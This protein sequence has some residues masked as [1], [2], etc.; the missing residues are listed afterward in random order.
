MQA[1]SVLRG[2]QIQRL[3]YGLSIIQSIVETTSPDDAHKFRDGGKGWTVVE[4]MCH[5][6]DFE[7]VFLERVKLT[8]EQDNPELPFPDPDLLAQMHHYNDQQLTDVYTAWREQRHTMIAYLEA[9]AETDW[10]RAAKHPKRGPFTLTDQLFLIA[11]HDSIHT[12]QMLRILR[13]ERTR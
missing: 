4:V 7:G 1:M 6:R 5:L 2:W 10:E 13:E 12:E 8:V 11:F 9:R 3:K